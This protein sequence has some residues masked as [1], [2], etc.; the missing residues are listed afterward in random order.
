MPKLVITSASGKLGGAVLHNLLEYN[1]IPPHDIVVSTSSSSSSQH[2]DTFKSRGVEVRH[3]SYDDPESMRAAFAGGER[4]LLVSTPRISMDFDDAP[5]GQ[6]RE[7]HHFAAV[8]AA[9]SAGVKH[10]YYT[11]L[12]FKSNSRSG[13][14]RAHNRTEDF[15][16]MLTDT[17]FTI[18]REGLYN[19]SWP[20]YLGHYFELPTE[21]RSEIVVAGDGHISW[22]AIDDLGLATATILTDEPSRYSGITLSLS[23]TNN[24]HS[25]NEIASMVSNV[26]GEAHTLSFKTVG[27]QEHER[28]YIE[29]R[30]LEPSYIRWWAKTY[31]AIGDGEADNHDTTLE[32]L[33]EKH[34]RVPKPLEQT[35]QE[36][37]GGQT[38]SSHE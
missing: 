12:G 23:T 31:D 11:S 25:L 1:L 28:H 17:G 13:V 5:Y 18:I 35:I 4:L 6:G 36:M 30:G 37:V 15:L 10:I 26:K 24:S 33:L 2:W 21:D 3:A 14:M 16:Q 7:A 34:G 8:Q 19:E 32:R 29:D 38:N 9:R 20:L 22:A 27:R